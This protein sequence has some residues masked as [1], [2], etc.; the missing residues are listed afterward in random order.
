MCAGMNLFFL[1]YK[2]SNSNSQIILEE[3]EYVIINVSF[4]Y[5][6]MAES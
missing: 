3:E 6:F 2:N 4:E 1:K 5:M